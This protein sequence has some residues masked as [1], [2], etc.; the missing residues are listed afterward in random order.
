MLYDIV[1]DKK[2]KRQMNKLD[3]SV[4]KS[5]F[6]K[7]D[8]LKYDV[9]LGKKLSGEFRDL[10]R[11]KSGKF[12]VIYSIRHNYIYILRI[13]HRK[14]IYDSKKINKNMLKSP[15][16]KEFTEKIIIVN[17]LDEVIG[18][19]ERFFTTD[20]DIYRVSVLIVKNSKNEIFL[21]KRA[22]NKIQTPGI[23]GP[24]VVGTNAIGEDYVDNILKEADE[25][26]GLMV[27][28]FEL[29]LIEKVFVKEKD[30]KFFASIFLITI[31]DYDS[32]H[33]KIDKDEVDSIEWFSKDKLKKELK[34]NKDKFIPSVHKYVLK[35]YDI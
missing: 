23:W 28:D 13:G 30:M 18:S 21:A 27:A 29:Q 33:L 25:E 7:L 19:K 1:Y 4:L 22:L 35:Y 10:Y 32:K 16:P 2:A 11:L 31:D 26:I 6:S 8:Q 34:E 12:R 9:S 5:I 20:K 14:N 3:L 17:K 24:S 15:R